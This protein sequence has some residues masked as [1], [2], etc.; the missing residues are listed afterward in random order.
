[1]E[2]AIL[3]VDMDA[4]FASVEANRRG[5]QGEPIVV[6]VYSGRT[7]NS[8]AV[9]AG[10]YEARDLGLHAGMPIQQAQARAEEADRD[11]HFLPADKEHYKKISGRIVDDILNEEVSAVEHA[12]IDEVY[13]DVTDNINSFEDAVDIA[14][15]VKDEVK[16]QFDLTCSIGVGPNKLVAKTSSDQ[17]KPDGLTAV[18]PDEAAAFMQSLPLDDIHGIGSKTIEKLK[19]LGITSVKELADASTARLVETFGEKRGIKIQHKAQGKDSAEVEEKRPKQ[20]SRLTT[21]EKNASDPE[22]ISSSLH[23]VAERLHDRLREEEAL[24]QTVTVLA[25]DTGLTTHTRSTTLETPVQDR[26]LLIETGNELLR[27]F[28]QKFNGKIRRIGLRA[29]NLMY[30]NGQKTITDF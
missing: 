14:A 23:N 1:M 24:F 6:C 13:L 3:H 16:Q 28:L 8:G 18:P 7:D 15:T 22:Y 2:Q 26:N 19:Q 10:S 20:L 27:D 9:A 25:I 11:V 17:D 4:F 12:S 29:Q 21:L 30:Q 5:L